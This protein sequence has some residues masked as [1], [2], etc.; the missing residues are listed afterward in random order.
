MYREDGRLS[1]FYVKGVSLLLERESEWSSVLLRSNPSSYSK[2]KVEIVWSS[3]FPF[4]FVFL[5]FSLLFFLII[6]V[7]DSFCF[8]FRGQLFIFLF[9]KG[10]GERGWISL[11]PELRALSVS[12]SV[13]LSVSVCVFLRHA[14]THTRAHARTRTHAYARTHAHT[15]NPACLAPSFCLNSFLTGQPSVCSVC[16]S[17]FQPSSALL[18]FLHSLFLSFQSCI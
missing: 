2:L 6:C 11:F 9:L 3:S 4:L 8:F 7:L 1:K 14:H 10:R 5:S 15:Q 12:V 13:C 17:L 18:W 16:L